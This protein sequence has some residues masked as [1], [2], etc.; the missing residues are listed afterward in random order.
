[1]VQNQNE[2]SPQHKVHPELRHEQPVSGTVPWPVWQHFS[3]PRTDIKLPL[4]AMKE[5]NLIQVLK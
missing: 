1:M 3:L 2:D 4:G 5:D